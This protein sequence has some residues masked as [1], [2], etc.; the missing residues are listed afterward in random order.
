MRHPGATM[1]TWMLLSCGHRKLPKVTG[2]AQWS[3]TMHQWWWRRWQYR[4]THSQSYYRT[5]KHTDRQSHRTDVSLHK[6]C[7]NYKVYL[8]LKNTYSLCN[9]RQCCFGLLQFVLQKFVFFDGFV[10]LSDNSLTLVD[11]IGFLFLSL[12]N[13]HHTIIAISNSMHTCIKN[14]KMQVQKCTFNIAKYRLWQN[15]MTAGRKML[16][17]TLGRDCDGRLWIRNIDFIFVFSSNQ[18]SISLGLGDRQM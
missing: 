14:S 5:D 17:C 7:W 6:C 3:P 18:S 16:K 1:K 2:V 12:W 9:F 13:S 15:K 8:W 11:G 4:A 10:S